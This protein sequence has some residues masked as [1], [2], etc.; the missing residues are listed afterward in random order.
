[1]PLNNP[2]ILIKNNGIT[3]G[4]VNTINFI[5]SVSATIAGNVAII[6]VGGSGGS[7]TITQVEVDF[8]STPTY[9]YNFTINDIIVNAT[10]HILVTQS[11]AAATGRNAD[12]NEMD[13]IIFSALPQN[14]K[15]ILRANSLNGPLVGKYRV[16][17][18][19]G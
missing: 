3:Q 1:M 7:A 10:S 5:G 18:M 14:G 15:F 8:G 9:T 6:N 11:G 12:E 13:P 16:N 19:V 4:A 2:P 17:Y